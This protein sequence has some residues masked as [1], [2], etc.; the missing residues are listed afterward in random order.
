M[1]REEELDWSTADMGAGG[2]GAGE[3]EDNE[4]DAGRGKGKEKGAGAGGRGGGG[5]GKA[6]SAFT[7]GHR[8]RLRERF[9][10]AGIDSLADYE[11]LELLL[12]RAIPRRDVKPLA[13]QLL[14]S[15]H[16]FNAVLNANKSDL[17]QMGLADVGERGIERILDEF[18]LSREV[19]RRMILDTMVDRPLLASWRSVVD[20][21]VVSMGRKEVE[22]FNILFLDKKNRLIKEESSLKK[23]LIKDENHQRGTIDHTPV[24]ARE[25]IKRALELGASSLVLV[26]NH[27]SGDPSPSR[28]DID[29]TRKL[30]AIAEPLG[31]SIH[32]HLI[33]SQGRHFSFKEN[34]L[35]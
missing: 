23:R 8:E 35:I 14:A 30:V 13:K 7:Q 2:D 15:Y 11:L 19:G 32:D 10:H 18:Q 3:G 4:K 1:R 17:Q 26:H 16:T 6:K 9:R 28:S 27:P 25:V 31:I 5:R 22:E 29:V 21:V 33:V 34:G 12:F 20:Y 24:Y